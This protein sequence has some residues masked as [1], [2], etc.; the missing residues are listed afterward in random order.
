MSKE[1]T[2]EEIQE[3]IPRILES[4]FWI[5]ELDTETIYARLHDDTDG[6]MEG[7]IAVQI[8][9]QGDVYLTTDE[10]RGPSL[11]FRTDGGGGMSLRTRTALLILALAIKMDTAERS[12]G[13]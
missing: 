6:K 12:Q 3:I 1:L 5:D 9:R 11:R 8:D 13:L 2:H 10:H 7:Q 4:F